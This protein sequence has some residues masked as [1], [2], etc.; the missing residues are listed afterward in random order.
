MKKLAIPM[1]MVLAGVFLVIFSFFGGNKTGDLEIKIQKAPLI[2]PAAHKVY[3]NPEALDGQYYLFKAKITNNGKGTLEDIVVKYEVPGYINQTEL[4]TVGKMIPGQ[5]VVITCYPVFDQKIT[6][7]TTESLERVNIEV[8]W[9]GADRRDILEES[10]TFKMLNRNDYIYSNIP[11]NEILGWADMYDNS[12]LLPSFVTPNDPI[13]KYYTQVIQEKVIKGEDAGISRKPE[14]AVRV[15]LG[16]YEATRLAKMVYGVTKG[17]PQTLDDVQTLLQHLRLPR[18]VITGNSGLCIE[19]SLLY[20]SVLSSAGLDPIIFLVPGHAYP[21]IKIQGQY[22]ALEATGIGGEGL[23]GTLTAEQAFKKGMEQLDEFVKAVQAGN[24]AYSF[25]DIHELNNRGVVSMHL[26]D[27][28]FLRRKVDEIAANFTTTGQRF[29]NINQTIDRSQGAVARYP[30]PLSFVIP[31]GWQTFPYPSPNFR[32]LI[33]QVI[34]PDQVASVSIYDIP[35]T[36]AQN[37]MNQLAQYFSQMGLSLQ[38]S[39][40]GNRVQGT[41]SNYAAVFQWK[42]KIAPGPNGYRFVAIGADQNYYQQY[43]GV[44]NSIYN[45]LN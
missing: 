40:D 11:S 12:V 24:P 39:I 36:S 8:A 3:A 7:K 1:I 6:E 16:I 42:G 19:L 9:A 17:I 28:E 44:I 5:S 41:S 45:S 30:G 20:A 22:F 37:A 35:A 14:E 27:N 18:E 26:D 31:A 33:A 4:A 25:I 43:S 29:R 32:L 38:Y 34:S 15:L 13:V 2:M 21:G 10:F 23:G